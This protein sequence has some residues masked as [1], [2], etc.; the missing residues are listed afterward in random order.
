[1]AGLVPAIHAL[2]FAATKTWMPGTRPGMTAVYEEP[3][4]EYRKLGNSNIAVSAVGVGCNN[5]GRRI[6]DVGA[7]R[8]VVHR[9]LDLGITLFDTADVYGNGVSESFLGE[10]L[11][12]RRAQVVIATKFGWG[13]PSGAS[14]RTIVRTVEASLKRL[15][16]DWID[17]YQVHFPDPNTPIDETLRALDDL[18]RQGKVRQIGCSNH[19]A[20]QVDDAQATSKRHGLAA[21]VTCQDEYSLLVRGIERD[22]V[23]AMQRH[24]M[25]LLPYAPLAGGFLSGKYQRDKPLPRN[26]RLAY[27]SH[28]A[29]DV[30]NDRNW[31]MMER[32]RGFAAK[33][34]HSVLELAFG[35]LLSRP[36]TASVIAGASTPEQVE[37]NVRA[38]SVRLSPEHVNELDRITA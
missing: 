17:L 34:D 1:M 4:V 2:A 13:S 8:A 35:W 23:P 11:G 18:V 7:A 15:N 27:S 33:T 19:S 9:A 12:A 30:I 6:H 26:A 21:F 36:V 14:R 25:T 31:G 16:T 37:Q 20:N 29:S 28:H 5:F 22:R 3:S 38:G 24:G 32:L 10:T